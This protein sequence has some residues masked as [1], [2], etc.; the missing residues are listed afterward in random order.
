MPDRR[1]L[2][3]YMLYSLAGWVVLMLAIA[4]WVLLKSTEPTFHPEAGAPVLFVVLAGFYSIY[5]VVAIL[6]VGAIC[7]CLRDSL[8]WRRRER[9]SNG[10]NAPG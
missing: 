6:L 10:K 4:G 2:R 8:A 7:W 5:Y 9:E 1:R 3:R